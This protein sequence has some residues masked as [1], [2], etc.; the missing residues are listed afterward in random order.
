MTNAQIHE[1]RRHETSH[2][3]VAPV[4]LM[5]LW[6][7]ARKIKVWGKI[8]NLFPLNDKSLTTSCLGKGKEWCKI[9]EFVRK[10]VGLML[11]FT[12]IVCIIPIVIAYTKDEEKPQILKSNVSCDNCWLNT[13]TPV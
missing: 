7:R 11:L 6:E 9:W 10:N 5:L 8:Y 2:H 12:A 1:A 3:T 13:E 4:Y